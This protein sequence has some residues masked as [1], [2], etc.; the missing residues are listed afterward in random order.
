MIE[1]EIENPAL[2]A[3]TQ[4]LATVLGE[5]EAEPLAS[6]RRLIAVKG[7]T[8]AQHILQKTQAREAA[9][10]MLTHDKTRRRTMG[11]VF[12]LLAKRAV[13]PAEHQQIWPGHTIPPPRKRAAKHPQPLPPPTIA[14]ED[15]R[16]LYQS[17]S[18]EGKARTVKIT[19]IGRPGRIS[20]QGAYILTVMTHA[21][22]PNLPRGLPPL[23]SA[24]QR[25]GVYITRKHWD[26]VATALDDPTDMLIVEGMAAYD[27]KLPGLV[28][29]AT[30]VITK[31]QQIAARA[32]QEA[33]P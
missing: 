15:R 1:Q 17:L 22:T 2:E 16:A 28:V 3:A 13:S 8:F 30:K 33:K 18:E 9:G 25:Y 7:V 23:P 24:P 5:Q 12:F 19:L 10:G 11:G 14:W 32:Q 20:H 6:L 4:S 29:Y 21:G 27:D 31:Q 26:Q